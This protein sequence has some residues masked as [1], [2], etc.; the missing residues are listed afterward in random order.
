MATPRVNL[1]PPEMRRH[2]RRLRQAWGWVIVAAVALFALT[3]YDA[4]VWLTGTELNRQAAALEVRAGGLAA[5]LQEV[6]DLQQRTAELKALQGRYQG[7]R[8]QAWS[9]V[10]ADL[11]GAL[12]VDVELQQIG[13]TEGG[14]LLTFG[15]GSLPLAAAAEDGLAAAP[16]VSGVSLVSARSDRPGHFVFILKVTLGASAPSA[17][18]P[19]MGAGQAAAAGA[20][21][22]A[23]DAEGRATP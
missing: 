21:Q 6:Q 13:T 20:G 15:A 12:P 1:L 18:A 2:Q 10:W 8:G 19:A 17:G 23:P 5:D 7:L 16:G 22:L 3:A 11:A 9:Q 4:S 14:V